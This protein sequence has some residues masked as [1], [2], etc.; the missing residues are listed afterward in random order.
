[1][2]AGRDHAVGEAHHQRHVG[3]RPRRDPAGALP[4]VDVAAQRADVD[5]VDAGL[6]GSVLRPARDMPC[7]AAR[8][9]LG[10]LERESA[11]RDDQLGVLGDLVPVRC[12]GVD[13]VGAAPDHVRQDH[14][15]GRAA[16]AVDRRRVAAVEVQEAVQQALRVMEAPRAAPAVGTAV[17]RVVA[18]L[19]PDARE[20]PR[21]E[22]ERLVPAHLDERVLPA[23]GA[24]LALQ[25]AAADGRTQ[26]AARVV[27]R[28]G[29]PGADRRRIGITGSRVQRDDLASAHLDVVVAPVRGRGRAACDE[30]HLL[31]VGGGRSR[32]VAA[33]LELLEL[34]SK[35]AFVVGGS[36]RAGADPGSRSGWNLSESRDPFPRRPWVRS[37]L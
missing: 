7:E 21:C 33:A 20:L 3:V 1:M 29:H 23:G 10:V 9:D 27:L 32:M 35:V 13:R 16:V 17:D 36:K 2:R 4:V 31:P 18:V 37:A 5:E 6:A 15:H 14:L 26:N 11:E 25:P 30:P 34:V 8:V 22:I 24:A 12:R 19:A 28:A